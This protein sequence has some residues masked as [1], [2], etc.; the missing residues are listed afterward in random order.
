MPLVDE[1]LVS[2]TFFGDFG[3]DGEA[4]DIL[5]LVVDDF[6]LSLL[7][8]KLLWDGEVFESRLLLSLLDLLLLLLLVLLVDDFKELLL[9]LLLPEPDFDLEDE[10]ELDN[11]VFDFGDTLV[12]C[13]T[14]TLPLPVTVSF[15]SIKSLINGFI[16]LDWTPPSL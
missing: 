14:L 11:K 7:L 15:T 10:V 9:E 16:V 3:T 12:W 6:F 13:A 1:T 8:L 4:G 5:R 2:V